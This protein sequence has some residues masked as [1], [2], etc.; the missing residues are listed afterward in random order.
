MAGRVRWRWLPQGNVRVISAT[1]FLTGMYQNI[2]GFVLQPFVLRFGGGLSL[3]GL[4]Q[5]LAGRLSGILSALVQPFGGYLADTRGRRKVAM[6]GSALAIA[7]MA[8]LIL[9][10]R[11]QGEPWALPGLVLPGFVCMGLSLVGAPALQS[12]VADST[13]P[14]RRASAYATTAFFWVL[15]GALLAIPGGLIAD[16]L[17]YG[18]VFGIALAFESV[19]LVLFAKFL[20]ETAP[21]AEVHPWRERIAQTLHPPREIRGLLF[22][23]AL[24]ASTWGLAS[25]IIYGLAA[26]EFGFSNAQLGAIAATWALFF[27]VFLI[28]TAVLVNR[29][30]PK[31]VIVF[32]EALG[33]PI[34]VAWL[35]PWWLDGGLE[36]FLAASVLNGLTAATWV[37]AVNTYVAN[38][39][40]AERRAEVLG[41]LAAFRG[42]A[43]FP[44]PFIGGVLY[45][46]FGYPV[47]ILA[48]LVGAAV[49]TAAIAILLRDPPV[50]GV[51]SS[52]RTP[53]P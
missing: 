38:W 3:V 52:P 8:L 4:F 47:P 22:V 9:A 27:A 11:F 37:P 41:G 13:D 39:T 31:R 40:S 26:K 23:V 2:L 7:A 16:R 44:A 20:R 12:T 1:N 43:A 15:P 17:G 33:V 32:S 49:T 36:F 10:A 18:A 50:H 25:G 53:S 29:H 24:D 42:L 14:R 5:A 51:G 46:A 21:A 35:L 19:N 6:L 45:D 28:P 34:M 30:G 48:N